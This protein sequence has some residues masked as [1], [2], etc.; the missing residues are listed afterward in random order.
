MDGC[1][2]RLIYILFILYLAGSQKFEVKKRVNESMLWFMVCVEKQRE[3]WL[4]S[5]PKTQLW[6]IQAY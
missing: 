5:P 2:D 1:D 4:E 3:M 6:E